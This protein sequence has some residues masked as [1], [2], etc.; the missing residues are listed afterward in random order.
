MAVEVLGVVLTL[1]VRV[2]SRLCQD[3]GSRRSRALAVTQRV[4][5]PYLHNDRVIWH[6][7]ALANS[8]AALTGAHLDPMIAKHAEAE[9]L[10]EPFG[11]DARAG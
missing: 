3:P 8:Q 6:N 2:I 5:D 7:V 11:C 10:P 4:F 9:S 1:A